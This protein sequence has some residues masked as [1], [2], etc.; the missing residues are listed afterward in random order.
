MVQ[1]TRALW[2]L[3]AFAALAIGTA[4][5]QIAATAKCQTGKVKCVVNKVNGR[6]K[7]E[8]KAAKLGA[9]VDSICMGKVT[10]KFAGVAGKSCMDKADA[11]NATVPCRTHD[12]GPT[13]EGKVDAFVADFKSTYYTNPGPQGL[14]PCWEAQ[15]K[16][17][18]TFVKGILNCE[19]KGVKKGLP[20]DSLCLAKAM[21]K[22]TGDPAKSCMEKLDA[23]T[24]KCA[25]GTG[26]GQ[27]GQ[28]AAVK[29]LAQA[30]IDDVRAEVIPTVFTIVTQPA[31]GT[32]GSVADSVPST[33][34][35]LVCGELAL[36]GGASTLPPGATP[37]GSRTK[38]DATGSPGSTRSVTGASSMLTG[39][40]RNCSVPGCFFGSPLPV[41]NGPLSTCIINTFAAAASGSLD[42]TA[43]TFTGTVPLQSAVT[44]T[45]NAAQPCPL[46][47]APT[48]GTCSPDAFNPGA[49]CIQD[50][51]TG[52]SHNCVASGPG[53]PPLMVTLSGLTTGTSSSSNPGGL[54]CPGQV[55]AGAFGKPSAVSITANGTVAGDLGAG[56]ALPATL[57]SVFCVAATGNVLI[58]GTTDLPGPGA[59]TLPVSAD[60]QF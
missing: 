52:Q 57:A 1:K 33:L 50:A 47:S 30:F 12:D 5:A 38:F 39:S 10:D 45:G 42:I 24:K 44:V 34:L 3:G 35:P 8:G 46:C 37:P 49:P 22:L 40:N 11:K 48:G 29:T 53:V 19:S 27:S 58:D 15:T 6:L 43:G 31:G 60:V 59:I 9:P 36:G 56:P 2:V 4:E 16:C 54:F 55:N 28:G 21:N 7:C 26:T 14:N 17:V 51:T 18:S 23:P 20:P 13:L 32:C 25:P 41:M